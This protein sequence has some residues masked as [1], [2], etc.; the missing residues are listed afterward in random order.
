[1]IDPHKKARDA[2]RDAAVEVVEAAFADGQISRPDYDLRVDRLLAAQT[3][4]EVQMLVQDLRRDEGEEVTE[5]VEEV[6][7]DLNPR[8]AV[9]SPQVNTK[10][11]KVVVAVVGAVFALGLVVPLVVLARVGSE[12]GVSTG[13]VGL[14]ETVDLTTASGYKRLVQEVED[15]TGSATVFSATIY[16]GYAVIEVP[17]DADSQRSYGWYFNG[18]WDEWTGKG[19][20]DEER[21][22]LDRISGRTVAALVDEVRGTIEDPSASYVLVNS[23]GRDDGVCLSAY[24]SN[25]YSETAYLDARCDGTVVFRYP[26]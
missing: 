16:P 6:T 11:I 25:D 21:F 20:A 5:A 4:G 12:Q 1:M 3:V 19:T 26:S 8:E 10:A 18:D 9:G 24:A 14:G 23:P 7:E 2:D 22:E 15:K 13:P 17:V